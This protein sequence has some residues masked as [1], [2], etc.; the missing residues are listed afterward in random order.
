M[1]HPGLK[2]VTN[3]L[4][5][6]MLVEPQQNLTE[7][8]KWVH[9]DGFKSEIV[10]TAEEEVTLRARTPVITQHAELVNAITPPVSAPVVDD[11]KAILIE[12]AQKNNIKI[13]KRWGIA[14]IQAALEAHKP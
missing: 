12:I 7:F 2:M 14:K 5:P 13:D 3:L 8:P 9:M 1:A 6:M 4:H 11:E 10:Q